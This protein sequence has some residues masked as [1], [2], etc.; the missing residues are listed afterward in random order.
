MGTKYLISTV[1]AGKAYFSSQ[2]V[3]VSAQSQ[4]IPRQVMLV[5]HRG[6]IVH[7]KLKAARSS[8]KSFFLF[9]LIQVTGLL[10]GAAHTKDGS[11]RLPS[12]SGEF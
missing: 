1:K 11:S 9:G 10:N 4:L 6:E 12:L 7:G 3:K 5:D 8:I 2:Y